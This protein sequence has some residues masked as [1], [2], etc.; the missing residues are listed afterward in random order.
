MIRASVVEN[1]RSPK[2]NN[3]SSGSSSLSTV[4]CGPSKVRKPQTK[5]RS[6]RRTVLV[7]SDE[8]EHSPERFYQNHHKKLKSLLP[9]Y[10]P[11]QPRSFRDYLCK[12][13]DIPKTDNP[14]RIDIHNHSGSAG[15]NECAI[16]RSFVATTFPPVNVGQVAG[17]K[18]DHTFPCDV[19][20][21]FTHHGKSDYHCEICIPFQRWAKTNGVKHAALKSKQLTIED[22]INDTAILNFCGV[23]QAHAHFNSKAHQEAID[24]FKRDLRVKV[25]KAH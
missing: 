5:H 3:P 14:R 20:P 16:R 13:L 23:V 19:F 25:S 7:S 8:E 1:V 10:L 24:F 15:T 22:I 2:S 6:K 21:Q 12:V 4:G 18:V 17:C 9:K 11:N